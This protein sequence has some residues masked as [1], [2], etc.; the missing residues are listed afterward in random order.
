MFNFPNVDREM[1]RTNILFFLIIGLRP[2][3][4]HNREKEFEK[5]DIKICKLIDFF[6]SCF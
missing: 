3:F 1:H 6:S 4:V 2:W 5:Q